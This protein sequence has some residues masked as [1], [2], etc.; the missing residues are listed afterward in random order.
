[1]IKPLDGFP[2]NVAAFVCHGHVTK[3]DYE[4][5]LIPDIEKMLVDHDKIRIY[6]EV[7][8][9]FAGIDVGAAWEDA[10][11]GF[12]HFLRWERFAVVTDVEWIKQA[13][14]L[15]GF[16]MPG[17]LRAFEPGEAQRAR[18]WVAEESS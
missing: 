16:L 15:V 6:Y 17:H 18:D 13:V 9:D 4:T 5:V 3:A 7:A 12:T 1:M 10:K 14:K 8:P 11:V 2:A